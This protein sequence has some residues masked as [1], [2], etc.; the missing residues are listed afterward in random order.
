MWE[1]L[2]FTKDDRKQK[3]ANLFPQQ[4]GW[5]PATSRGRAADDKV[6]HAWETNSTSSRENWTFAI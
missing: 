4:V 1:K 5:L 6:N 2:N 3:A